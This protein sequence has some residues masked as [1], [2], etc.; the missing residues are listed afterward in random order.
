MALLLKPVLSSG[1]TPTITAKRA[2]E[3][4]GRKVMAHDSVYGG[5]VLNDSTVLYFLGA[6]ENRKPLTV[7]YCPNSKLGFNQ[8]ERHIKTLQRGK[9][10]VT[11]F[12]I[13]INKNPFIVVKNDR[14][15]AYD[16]PLPD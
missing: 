9:L 1:Q 16:M 6:N 12:I 14:D 5:R 2:S 3:Y 13:M 4:A 11:G 15:I 8:P 10:Y 7:I